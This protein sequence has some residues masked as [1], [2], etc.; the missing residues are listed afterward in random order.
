MK[1]KSRQARTFNIVLAIIM[2]L[3]TALTLYPVWFS[4]INSLNSAASINKNGYELLIPTTITFESWKAVLSN[5][6]IMKAFGITA[7]RTVIVTVFQTLFTAMFAYGYSK[8]YLTGKRFY[9]VI[10]F[11][12][13]YL[14]GGVISYFLLFNGLKLYNTYWVY[15]IPCLFGGF[16][17]VVIFRANFREIPESLEES[18]KLDGASEYTIFFRI[19]LPLSK[20]VLTA[21]GIFTAVGTWN[22]YTQTLYYTRSTDIQTLSY[23]MLTV[24]K[25]S[26][27]AENMMTDVSNGSATTSVLTSMANQ[28]S[29]YKTIELAC[30]VISSIPLIVVYPFVQRFFEKGLMVGSVKG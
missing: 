30:M 14:N 9:T 11:I 20:P 10:G 1:I 27:T 25:S 22:D 15:I 16:Y 6:E 4:L 28:A 24:I 23:Y 12:S 2:I 5:A 26:Q 29:N 21:L 7:S 17:N 13:M 8:S 3:I 18:A 19:I